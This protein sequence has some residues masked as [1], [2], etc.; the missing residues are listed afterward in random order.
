MHLYSVIP[1]QLWHCSQLCPVCGRGLLFPLLS[2]LFQPLS[3]KSRRFQQFVLHFSPLWLPNSS[4]RSRYRISWSVRLPAGN[5]GMRFS[6]L[7]LKSKTEEF[8][9]FATFRSPNASVQLCRTAR[10]V[11]AFEPIYGACDYFRSFFSPASGM[12]RYFSSSSKL[13]IISV[14]LLT[15]TWALLPDNVFYPIIKLVLEVNRSSQ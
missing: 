8:S 11:V 9:I 13:S 5:T 14:F 4:G 6:F 1:K 15:G 12:P 2:R 10:E 3:A 7:D